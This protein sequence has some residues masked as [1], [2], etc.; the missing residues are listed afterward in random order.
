M[1]REIV[2]NI[3]SG[4]N[5]LTLG[6]RVQ[7]STIAHKPGESVTGE[8]IGFDI[9]TKTLA[10]RCIHRGQGN[11]KYVT[12]RITNLDYVSTLELKDAEKPYEPI[13]MVPS[14]KVDERIKT[15]TEQRRKRIIQSH[16]S[17]E[18]QRLMDFV[19]KTLTDVKWD[20]DKLIVMEMVV[21]HPPYQVGN[22]QQ[23]PSAPR[24]ASV[25]RALD[26][27]KKVVEKFNSGE[28]ETERQDSQGSTSISPNSSTSSNS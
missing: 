15:S 3:M 19:S 27:I 16:V 8:I 1:R 23:L 24:D 11:K 14:Q 21:I 2:D 22:V 10:T 9:P 28:H 7:F 6:S 26:H 20:G 5:S 4:N 18:G 17:P 25:G 12:I 13:P